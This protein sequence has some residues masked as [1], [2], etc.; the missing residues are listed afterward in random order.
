VTR[1][2]GS[3]RR[4]KAELNSLPDL[5]EVLAKTLRVW[6][7]TIIQSDP[8]GFEKAKDPL[9]T[10]W[11]QGLQKYCGTVWMSCRRAKV[12]PLTT[13]GIKYTKENQKLS[14]LRVTHEDFFALSGVE[15][16]GAFL[17]VVEGSVVAG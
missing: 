14:A 2:G 15:G 6:Y 8:P 1:F 17:S 11:S 5:E 9:K 13:Q 10:V 12:K 4:P 7:I 16:S 3:A